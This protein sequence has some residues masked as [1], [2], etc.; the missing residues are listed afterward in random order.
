[1]NQKPQYFYGVGRRK[2]AT[3]RAKYTP[4][5]NQVEISVNKKSIND[6]FIDFYK[7]TILSSLELIGVRT[8]KIE[9]FIKGGG[10]MGQAEAARLAIS[11]A[12]L[13][14]DDGFRPILRLN[15]LL[16][17]DNRKVLSKRPGLRK[18]RK[19]EQWSKR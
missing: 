9:L 2:S 18:A 14:Q 1:M 12:I 16:T 5:V 13:K 15:G 8:G 19:R 17:T 11:K 3:A 4:D 6:Y 7:Q 10:T